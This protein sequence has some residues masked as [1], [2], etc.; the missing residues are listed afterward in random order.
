VDVVPELISRNAEAHAGPGVSFVTLDAAVTELPRGDLCL[1]RQVLQH[2]SNH[3][4]AAILRQCSDYPMVMITEHWPAVSMQT[5]ANIDKPHGGDT[6]L[7]RGSWVDITAT[8]FSCGPTEN[9]LEVPVERPLYADGETI[10]TVIWWPAGRPRAT[11]NPQQVR[12]PG[13]DVGS[14]GPQALPA[15]P[16]EP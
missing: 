6:R 16:T 11:T 2:L 15:R 4:I 8:P 10:R 5:V 13:A 12:G 14:E 9:A 7:D 3:E 1:I